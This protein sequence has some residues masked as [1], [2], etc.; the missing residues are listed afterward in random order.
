MWVSNLV[1]HSKGETSVEVV[2]QDCR[3]FHDEFHD[4]IPHE[5]LLSV[6]IKGAEVGRACGTCETE[7][8]FYVVFGWET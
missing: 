2:G 8:K 6:Q 1:P 5:I 4:F 3:K 7:E